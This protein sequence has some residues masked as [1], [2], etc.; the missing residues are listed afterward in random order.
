VYTRT[1]TQNAVYTS[2][3]DIRDIG[4]LIIVL[5]DKIICTD[6]ASTA[7]IGLRSISKT[8]SSAADIGA[9]HLLSLIEKLACNLRH[10]YIYIYIYVCVC[11]FV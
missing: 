5:C 1:H 9:D 10:K 7:A 11:V 2:Y 8:A 4:A 3:H 6:R